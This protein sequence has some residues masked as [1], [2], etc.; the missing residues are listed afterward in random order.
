MSATDDPIAQVRSLLERKSTD[1][2]CAEYLRRDTSQWSDDA[3]E[4]MRRIVVQRGELHDYYA[5]AEA[6]SRATARIIAAVFGALFGGL[7]AFLLRPSIMGEQLP[8]SAVIT[9]GATLKGMGQ[10]AAPLAHSSFNYFVAGILVGA[11]TGFFLHH[12]MSGPRL[13][14]K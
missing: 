9:R 10:L 12:I 6:A 11:F 13:I 8:F 5:E 14:T 3:F 1:E 4:A 7:V 2:L